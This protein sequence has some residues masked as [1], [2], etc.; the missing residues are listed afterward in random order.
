MLTNKFNLPET[1]LKAVES[2]E[3]KGGFL[4]ASGTSVGPRI[5]WL[6]KRHKDK[7]VEDVSN[8]IWALLGTA[9]HYILDKGEGKN[10]LTEEYLETEILGKTVSGSSDL[11]SNNTVHDYKV[12]S[13]WKVIY[14]DKDG[15]YEWQNQLNTYAYLYRKAGF[16]VNN[17]KI[18]AILRDWSARDAS[19]KPDYPQSQIAIIQIPLWTMEEQ[20]RFLSDKVRNFLDHENTPDHLLP[21]CTDLERWYTGDKYAV[22]KK[23]NKRALSGGVHNTRQSA[24]DFATL[25]PVPTEIE[26]RPGESKRCSQYCEVKNFCNQYLETQ[27]GEK[28]N[29]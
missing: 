18:I 2:H 15:M 16:E 1:F 5:F 14:K 23:G 22:K 20:E 8:R 3:H 21:F 24:E 25:Q 7:V 26:H 27:K 29:D 9:V 4:S 6:K 28:K 17:L 11:F 10:D 12:T 19:L 13:V